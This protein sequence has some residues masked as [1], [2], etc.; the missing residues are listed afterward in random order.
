M[1]RRILGKILPK[2]ATRANLVVADIAVAGTQMQSPALN[3]AGT[4]L[5]RAAEI[6]IS[7][8]STSEL[9]KAGRVALEV[10]DYVRVR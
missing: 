5:L 3:N 4:I 6:V 10:F 7:E 9:Q 1:R 2:R 8:N